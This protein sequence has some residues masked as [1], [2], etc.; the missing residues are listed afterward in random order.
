MTG[1]LIW[2]IL[3]KASP[4]LIPFFVILGTLGILQ[5]FFRNR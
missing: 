2:N 1:Q 4:I 5:G 3:V